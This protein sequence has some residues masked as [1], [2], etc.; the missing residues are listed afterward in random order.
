MGKENERI[1]TPDNGQFIRLFNNVR[2]NTDIKPLG[3]MILS[4]IISYQLQGK[5]FFMSNEGIAYEYGTPIATV[6]RE[7]K[8]LEKYLIKRKVKIPSKD[9]GRP[10]PRR[11]LKVMNLDAW[12][13]IKPVKQQIVDY[14]QFKTPDA[15]FDWLNT[16][17]GADKIEQFIIDNETAYKHL[18]AIS[19]QSIRS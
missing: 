4:H 6:V 11:Y 16:N 12:T 7:I 5:E 8:R 2:T 17:I 14:T 10:S 9:G 13:I 3:K 18:E 19:K 15:F 1:Q